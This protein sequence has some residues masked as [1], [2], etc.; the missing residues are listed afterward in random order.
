MKKIILSMLLVFASITMVN[1]NSNVAVYDCVEMA[2]NLQSTL[3]NQGV[4]MEQANS[5]AT[6]A[7]NACVEMA[8]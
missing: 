2:F 7:Y 4:S 1:A 3:M 6:G 8:E 5:I